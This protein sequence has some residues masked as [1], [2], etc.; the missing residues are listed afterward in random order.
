[1]SPFGIGDFVGAPA[2]NV[3]AEN[4]IGLRGVGTVKE[5]TVNDIF[6]FERTDAN[7][8]VEKIPVSRIAA[9]GEI[10]GVLIETFTE[11]G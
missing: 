5:V 11:S 10:F 8:G 4:M 1:M 7:D 6:W 3:N 9:L 2:F